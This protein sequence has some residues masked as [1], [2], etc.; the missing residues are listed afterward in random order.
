MYYVYRIV[1][2]T[3]GKS[4]IGISDD[5]KKRWRVHRSYLNHNKHRNRKLQSAWNKYGAENFAFTVTEECADRDSAKSREIELIAEFDTLHCGYNLT[6]GG[7]NTPDASNKAVTWN[8]V[9]YLSIR[10]AAEAN[11][12]NIETFRGWIRRGYSCDDDIPGR[13]EKPVLW[14]GVQYP[15]IRSAAKALGM[16]KAGFQKYLK[17]G[18]VCDTDISPHKTPVE[19]DGKHYESIAAAARAEGI[20]TQSMFRRLR[21]GQR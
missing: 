5:P 1:C 15:S 3:S 9:L 7:D 12:H 10:E 20:T 21:R 13:G 17:R 2:V 8:E 6:I 19:W 11:G 14:N 4:Y 18:Y 16:D